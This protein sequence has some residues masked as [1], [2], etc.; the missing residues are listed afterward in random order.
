MVSV[1]QIQRGFAMFIDNEIA[2]AFSGW[3]KAVIGGAAGLVAS[4]LPQII[5]QY[6]TH[7]FVSALG[8]YDANSKSVDIESL[9]NAFVPKLEGEKIPITIPVIGTI[10]MGRSEF[11]TLMTY[12]QEI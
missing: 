2:P 1:S 12:I 9:Y 11:D 3:Q 5:N 6:S 7:P 10:K 8:L 4:K